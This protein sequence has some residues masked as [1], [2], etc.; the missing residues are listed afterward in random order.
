MRSK[1]LRMEDSDAFFREEG[2]RRRRGGTEFT[3]H[4][5]IYGKYSSGWIIN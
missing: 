3:I 4:Q 5:V 2:E 1:D